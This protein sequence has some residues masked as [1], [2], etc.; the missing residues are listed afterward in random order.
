MSFRR[1]Q[2][3]ISVKLCLKATYRK[4]YLKLFSW[5]WSKIYQQKN[6]ETL[7]EI[8]RYVLV[9]RVDQRVS[10]PFLSKESSRA[11]SMWEGGG[12]KIKLKRDFQIYIFNYVCPIC[13]NSFREAVQ[14]I[15][16]KAFSPIFMINCFGNINL[17]RIRHLLYLFLSFPKTHIGAD[18]STKRYRSWV[19]SKKNVQATLNFKMVA[20][21]QYGS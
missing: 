11:E 4:I 14:G 6:E 1:P 19:T 21:F 13:S 7:N 17:W 18:K 10:L 16:E 5:S 20:I 15:Q 3:D 12:G 2:D 8:K 9:H